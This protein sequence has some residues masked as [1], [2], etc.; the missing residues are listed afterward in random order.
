MTSPALTAEADNARLTEMVMGLRDQMRLYGIKSRAGL[1]RQNESIAE[2]YQIIEL[3][4]AGKEE[5]LAKL[6]RRHIRSWEPIFIEALTQVANPREPIVA[7][8]SRAR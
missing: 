1:A 3:A 2:H 8:R 4:M 7:N 6:L 5:T